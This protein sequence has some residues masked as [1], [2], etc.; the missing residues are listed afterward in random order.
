MDRAGAAG[1]LPTVGERV[2]ELSRN[3]VDA[4]RALMHK[5]GA[6]TW[7]QVPQGPRDK[8]LAEYKAALAEMTR[9]GDRA[10]Y[11]AARTF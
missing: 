8:L 11:T 3:F 7:Q 2:N 6:Q 5:T 10:R 1:R 4:Q 9:A